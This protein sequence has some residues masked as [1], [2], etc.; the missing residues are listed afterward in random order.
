MTK[1]DPIFEWNMSD[2]EAQT[3]KLAVIWEEQLEKLFPDDKHRKM[4]KKADPRKCTLF[5]FCWK[6]LRETRGL[7]KP[8]EYK[9]YI[10]A[11]LQI[12]RAN[13]GRIEPNCLVGEKAWIRWKVWQRLFNKKKQEQHG[14]SALSSIS[15]DPKVVREI[16]CT[17][18]FLYEKCDG[19]PSVEIL[20]KFMK[21]GKIILWINSCKISKFYLALSPLAAKAFDF[22]AIENKCGF[23]LQLYRDKAGDGVN[24]YFKQEFIEEWT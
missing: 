15:L 6:L 1:F 20:N 16:D 12:L 18:R 3:Y 5:R 4:P 7:L 14:E 17:K 23:S 11:N 13:K 19:P 10:I 24:Q 21:E 9:L 8:E 22:E 2:V